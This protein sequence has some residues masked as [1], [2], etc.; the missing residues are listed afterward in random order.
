MD[1]HEPVGDGQGFGTPLKSTA[2]TRAAGHRLW[3][4]VA[5]VVLVLAVFWQIRGFSLLHYDDDRIITDNPVVGLGLTVAGIRWAF[6]T[7]FG[8]NW[9]PL[10]WISHMID[11]QFF[12]MNPAGHHLVNLGLHLVVTLLL[13]G[14]LIAL[15]GDRW[16]S[17]F[18]AA[19]FAVHPIHVESVA[20]V[21]QRKDLLMAFFGLLTLHAYLADLRRP[22][23]MK[24][25]LVIVAFTCG[26]M[27]KALL[28]TLPLLLLLLD[29]WPL[30]RFIRSGRAASPYALSWVAWR[31]VF[32][33][34][35]MLA[36]ALLAGGLA[37]IAQS[38]AGGLPFP[39]LAMSSRCAH[40]L[41]S[42]AWY[43]VKGFIPTGLAAFYPY[44]LAGHPALEVAGAGVLLAGASFVA[45]AARRRAPALM[46]GWLWFLVSLLPVAGLVQVGRQAWADRYA[47]FTLVGLCLAVA[48]GAADI[49]LRRRARIVIGVTATLVVL[50]FSLASFIQTR[51]W[52]ND[53]TLWERALQTTRG[54]YVA[55]NNLG[56]FLLGNGFPEEAGREFLAAVAI[57][58]DSVQTRNNLGLTYALQGRF[59]EAAAE[60][61][62]ALLRGPAP[63]QIYRNLGMALARMGRHS[64]A[65][66]VFRQALVVEPDDPETLYLLGVSL[67]RQGFFADAIQ[68]LER[69]VGQAPRNAVFAAALAVARKQLRL[70]LTPL[71]RSEQ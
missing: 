56:T 46:V 35:P 44:P 52:K 39:G 26:L 24:K 60:F 13:Y 47:Y 50:C 19:L 30:G 66:A 33:K 1:L 43:L 53:G 55:H 4:G 65:A 23:V 48:W 34:L 22:G 21:N 28:V 68:V 40:T 10:T 37:F 14:F 25:G 18:A 6:T 71:Q 9:F 17:L 5:L 15:T 59:V 45:G 57:M 11:V 70:S 41:V 3:P 69:A 38:N 8:G 49:A 29:F 67:A 2:R 42:L 20:W 51:A 36:I 64:D 7:L 12:G 16:R 32:E 27:S 63:P 61:R 58:P 54:N 31:P 62:E